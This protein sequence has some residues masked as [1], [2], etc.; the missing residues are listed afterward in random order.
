MMPRTIPN[1][2][3]MRMR[4]RLQGEH[5][6]CSSL[7]SVGVLSLTEAFASRGGQPG[8]SAATCMVLVHV[9]RATFGC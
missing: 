8:G 5:L 7:P 4:Y 6:G 3:V 2:G 9:A 1:I